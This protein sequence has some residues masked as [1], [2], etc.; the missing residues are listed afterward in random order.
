MDTFW[1][2]VAGVVIVIIVVVVV[3]GKILSSSIEE[4]TDYERVERLAE[5][6]EAR[7]QTELA[8]AERKARQAK[9]PP[10]EQKTIEPS[11]QSELALEDQV[12]AQQL[13]QLAETEFRIGRK[14]LMTFDRC[15]KY[16]RELIEKYPDSPEAAKA[17][18]LLR[19][20]P[21]RYRKQYN[22]TDEEMG[23]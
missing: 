11:L 10:E 23:L 6:Q 19:K 18:V 14:P 15:V 13:Y 22:L 9:P 20:I 17:K 2:K 1:V 7:L 5:Q 3:L 21:E 4:A 16:C 8:E 12:R